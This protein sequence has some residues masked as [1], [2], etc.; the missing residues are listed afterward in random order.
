M[1]NQD[2]TDNVTTMLGTCIYRC[3]WKQTGIL[4]WL[5]G[6]FKECEQPLLTDAVFDAVATQSLAPQ[7]SFVQWR[8]NNSL[9]YRAS[10][11]E[12]THRLQALT[13]LGREKGGVFQALRERMVSYPDRAHWMRV[14]WDLLGLDHCLKG[15]F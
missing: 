1:G 13:L 12:K 7:D 8:T 2:I 9:F 3:V 6:F 15:H 14:Y 10:F 5:S 11:I 4:E